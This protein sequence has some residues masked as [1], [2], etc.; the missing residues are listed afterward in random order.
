VTGDW[1]KL[2]NAGALQQ[3]LHKEYHLRDQI[4]AEERGG[5]CGMNV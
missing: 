4:T 1:T 5:E 3:A 2:Q